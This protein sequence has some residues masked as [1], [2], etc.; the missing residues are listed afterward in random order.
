MGFGVGIFNGLGIGVEHIDVQDDDDLKWIIT[1]D[2][3]FVRLAIF[4]FK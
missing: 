3:L 4:K 2:I 1:I